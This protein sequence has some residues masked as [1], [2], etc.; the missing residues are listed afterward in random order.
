[1]LYTKST[2]KELLEVLRKLMSLELLADFRLV[3]G[4]ALS[5]LRGHR[6]SEDID[7]FTYQEYGA[8][9]FI[10]VENE[11]KQ[12][13]PYLWNTSD[14]FPE[15]KENKTGLHLYI[16]EDKKSAVKVDILNWNDPF[17]FE[18]KIIDGIRLAT[19]EEIA[20]M[21]LDTISRGGRKKDFWDLSEI[22]ESYTLSALMELYQK[23]YE[24]YDIAEV[25]KGLTDYAVAEKMPDPICLKGKTWETI[26]QQ[27]IN[28]AG[29]L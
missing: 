14:E 10:A 9:D 18:Q 2:G 4:T 13:F 11:I 22:L 24:Y 15:L 12:A 29:K 3:G 8:V 5:L 23:K 1:M 17:Y 7:M 25:K 6:I 21:K 28:E 27:I 19:L 16:G 20:T 26:K